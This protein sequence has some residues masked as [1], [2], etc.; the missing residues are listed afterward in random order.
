MR[1]YTA[2]LTLNFQ[3][4]AKAIWVVHAQFQIHVH[5]IYDAI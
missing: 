4:S 5:W 1:V 2:Y 3:Y